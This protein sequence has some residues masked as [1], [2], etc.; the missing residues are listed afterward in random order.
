[1][2]RNKDDIQY[3]NDNYHM[4][5]RFK[6]QNKV[7]IQNTIIYQNREWYRDKL[8]SQNNNPIYFEIDNLPYTRKQYHQYI[9]KL[10]NTY[11][12]LKYSKINFKIN[13]FSTKRKI[14][15]FALML[16]WFIEKKKNEIKSKNKFVNECTRNIGIHGIDLFTEKQLNHDTISI[17][18]L[19]YKQTEHQLN[20]ERTRFL[21][22]HVRN[23]YHPATKL[24]YYCNI[25]FANRMMIKKS[26]FFID[27]FDR[28]MNFPIRYC[29]NCGEYVKFYPVLEENELR[30]FSAITMRYHCVCNLYKNLMSKKLR[31]RADIIEACNNI[32]LKYIN[33][34]KLQPNK[35]KTYNCFDYFANIFNIFK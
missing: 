1:M 32:M 29:K 19:F 27:C 11:P 30:R 21:I 23:Y 15:D 34:N 25:P 5:S 31:E 14:V 8:M 28:M 20:F 4:N 18:L 24:K 10:I 22:E 2:F 9:M 17:I 6:Y 13:S 3:K 26:E 7:C 33:K 16:S 12:F 35:S